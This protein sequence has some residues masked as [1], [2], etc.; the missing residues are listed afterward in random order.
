MLLIVGLGNPGDK[1]AGNR[2]NIGFMAVDEIVRRH[3]FLP[4]R[5]RFQSLTHEGTLGGTKVLVIKPQTFI[6]E[7][8][9]AVSEA[10]KFYK[11]APQNIIVLYDELDV[12]A[13]KIKTRQG[14]GHAGH[15]GIRSLMAHMGPDFHRIRIGI[16]HP[17]D[18]DLVHNHVLSDFGKRDSLWLNPLLDAI[19]DNAIWLGSGDVTRFQSEVARQ[20]NPP[21][22]SSGKKNTVTSDADHKPAVA[23]SVKLSASPIKKATAEGPMA[24]ALKALKVPEGDK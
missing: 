15:N 8:G 18:K 6:N 5:S 24:D 12:A 2:H 10:A 19:A 23:K 22:E 3:N 13:G 14:G 1:Y 20:V 21:R 9:R 11:I 17:G 16:G 7:S 4:E